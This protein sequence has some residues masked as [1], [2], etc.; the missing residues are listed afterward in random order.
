MRTYKLK[1]ALA[2]TVRTYCNVV[3]RKVRILNLNESN[4]IFWIECLDSWMM[5]S[6]DFIMSGRDI[7]IAAEQ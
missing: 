5:R 6:D 3:K 1:N 4:T 7:E 2:A